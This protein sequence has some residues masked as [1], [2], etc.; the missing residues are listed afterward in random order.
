MTAGW[1]G[2]NGVSTGPLASCGYCGGY[3]TGRAC[4]R[5][6]AFE[7]HPDG[8]VKRVEFFEPFPRPSIVPM[9]IQTFDP[10]ARAER[11]DGFRARLAR[12]GRT[13]DHLKRLA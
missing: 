12:G 3:H 6:K 5:V 9:P 11:G 8:K 10:P 1:Q 4:P 13:S 2:G 7:Y